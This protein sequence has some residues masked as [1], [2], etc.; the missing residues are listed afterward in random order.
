MLLLST[1]PIDATAARSFALLPW[2]DLP[3]ARLPLA[4]D[5][6]PFLD[7]EA[8]AAMRLSSKSHW[9][10]PVVLPSGARLHVLASHPTPPVFDGPED[11]NGRRNAD[12]IQFWQ[13]YLDGVTFADDAG[14]TAAF[15]GDTF[16]I[17]GDLNS[18][19][20]DGDSS[21]SAVQALLMHPLIQDPLPKSAGGLEASALQ[22]L[23][24][25]HI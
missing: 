10:V 24:L 16:A 11:L 14:L 7:P 5:G 9:D 22:G 8:E 6:T 25:I 17:M 4:D 21:H 3:D 13:L 12:E 23:S 2:K 19:P 15:S 20:V 1:F 18:D